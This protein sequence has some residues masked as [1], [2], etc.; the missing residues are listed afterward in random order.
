MESKVAGRPLVALGQMTLRKNPKPG[1]NGKQK[2]RMA[3]RAFPK[4][5]S[6]IPQANQEEEAITRAIR[7]H[8][9]T[10]KFNLHPISSKV[11]AKVASCS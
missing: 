6:Q 11:R 8:Y 10:S 2:P 7:H 3:R 4:H 9:L 5:C 1:Q